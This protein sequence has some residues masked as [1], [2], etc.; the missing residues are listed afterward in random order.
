MD[1]VVFLVCYAAIGFLVA[2]ALVKFFPDNFEHSYSNPPPVVV[3]VLA[4]TI[5]P[6]FAVWWALKVPFL[7]LDNYVSFVRGY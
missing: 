7:L 3:F 6:V 1:P 2:S 4:G 5:W